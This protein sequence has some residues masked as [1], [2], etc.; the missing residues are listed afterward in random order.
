MSAGTGVLHS[1]HNPSATEGVHFLQIWIKP[2]R[3]GVKPGYE[4]KYFD[5]AEKRGRLRLIVS[6]DGA[7]GSVTIHQ[8]AR[9]YAGLFEGSEQAR[10]EVAEGRRVYVHLVRGALT[11]NGTRL[12]AG[13]A[14]KLSEVSAVEIGSGA[15]AEVLV[16][17][18]PGDIARQ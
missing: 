8:D 10:L 17:D 11:V 14:L 7:N 1:E 6:G 16:F 4:Q 18:L 2:D 3:A 12:A 5:A 13:D 15:D 9:L